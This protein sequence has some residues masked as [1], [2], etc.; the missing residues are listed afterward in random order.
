VLAVLLVT[1]AGTVSYR[2][3]FAREE[4]YELGG[5]GS[6]PAPVWTGRRTALRWRARVADAGEW[7]TPGTEC[8]VRGTFRSDLQRIVGAEL[9]MD[10]GTV[11]LYR[12]R[13]RDGLGCDVHEGPGIGFG[14]WEYHATCRDGRGLVFDTHESHARIEGTALRP[15]VSLAVVPDDGVH[16][17]PP[18]YERSVGIFRWRRDLR[19]AA[20]VDKRAGDRAPALGE[21]CDAVLL[22]NSSD[23]VPCRARITCGEHIAY[24]GFGAGFTH[25]VLGG[26]GPTLAT[27]DDPTGKDG[28][29][30]LRFDVSNLRATVRDEG[31]DWSA[32]FALVPVEASAGATDPNPPRAPK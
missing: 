27:D 29:P 13:S 16:A 14:V 20:R 23:D 6:A 3:F 1:L 25:C 31:P 32:E 26:D 28:D 8:V 24:G 21:A 19:F 9:A 11:A 18:L 12:G 7:L 2:V 10:C 5:P 17:G 30:V 4:A 15:G 22:P